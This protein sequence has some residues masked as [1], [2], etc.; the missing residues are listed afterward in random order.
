MEEKWTIEKLEQE[1]PN[2]EQRALGAC[3][4]LRGVAPD[5]VQSEF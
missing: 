5:V 1:I 4:K 3:G 2:A